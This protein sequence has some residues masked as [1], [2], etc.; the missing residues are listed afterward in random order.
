[1]FLKKINKRLLIAATTILVL[2]FVSGSAYATILAYSLPRFA[3]FPGQVSIGGSYALRSVAGEPAA[4]VS[5]G[6]SFTLCAGFL[7]GAANYQ[8]FLPFIRR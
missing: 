3:F 6:G 4:G 1:M 8:T 5:S 7:C 2:A